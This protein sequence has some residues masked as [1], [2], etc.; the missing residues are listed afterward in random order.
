MSD[1]DRAQIAR[2]RGEAYWLLA[3]LF[4]D[5][6]DAETLGRTAALPTASAGDKSLADDLLAVLREAPDRAQLVERLA[7][8][9]ARLFRGISEDYGPPPPYESLWRE[10]RMMG[11][12]TVRVATRYLEA[13]YQPQGRFAPCDH[14]VEELSFMAA[15]CNAEREAREAGNEQ[16]AER[17]AGHQRRFLDEHLAAWVAEYCRSLSE[18]AR[19]P[20]YRSLARL[21]TGVLEQD[22]LQLRGDAQ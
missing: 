2:Q 19:E 6:L 17:A 8:E 9:H 1:A 15:L 13:G 22:A 16:D 10:G 3:R 12:S 18:R 21:T 4:A 5:P 7:V 11:D 14:L 20:L